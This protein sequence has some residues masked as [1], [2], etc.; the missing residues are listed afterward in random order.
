MGFGLD[1]LFGIVGGKGSDTGN[2]TGGL[3]GE[4]DAEEAAKQAKK[5]SKITTAENIA[6]YEDYL[7][8]SSDLLNPYLQAGSQA[9]SDLMDMRFG[10][11]EVPELAL[12]AYPN[13][14]SPTLDVFN[15]AVPQTP[16]LQKFVFDA[17]QLGGTDAYK[18]RYQQ[19]L[20]ATDRALA[21]NRALTSGNRLTAL[22]DYGQGAASQEYENE[23][24]RQLQTNL[25]NNQTLTDQ[26]GLDVNRFGNMLTVNQQN[27]ATKLS[28]YGLGV[29]AYNR[30]FSENQANNQTLMSQYG[31]NQN[32]YQTVMD[33]L[34]GLADQGQT[35]AT[36]LGA[37]QQTTAGNIAN[38]RTG[39]AANQFAASLLPTQEK[40]QFISGL[41]GIFGN[42]AGA[43]TGGGAA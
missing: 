3:I 5:L 42:V 9:I 25:T 26:Y 36:N 34:F 27:N 23:W 13:V 37:M 33:R 38:A 41:A 7:K 22:Q 24:Q 12:F 30:A 31:L 21:A 1:N 19:G 15:Y 14:E 2:L 32:K 10:D 28:Q 29:D 18:W 43:Y 6:T 40:Q 4:S 39:N 35:A 8:Q 11:P 17:T 16:E 20:Q